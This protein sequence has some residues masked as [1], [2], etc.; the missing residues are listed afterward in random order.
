MNGW[1]DKLPRVTPAKSDHLK[2]VTVVYPYYDQPQWLMKQV[3]ALRHADDTSLVLQ[4]RLS[5]IVVDDGSPRWSA[6]DTLVKHGQAWGDFLRVFRIQQDI[7]WNWLAARNI[8]AH[9]AAGDWLLLTDLDHRI[10]QQTLIECT[11]G[12]HNTNLIYA[13]SRREHTGEAIPPHSASFFLTKE[14]FWKVGGY[15]ETLSGH[16]GT[17]G[18]WRRRCTKTA[19]M[20]VLTNE[21]V[22]YEYVGDSST[23]TYERK[24]PS[25]AAAVKRLVAARGDV[26]RPKVLS[27]PYA[28]VYA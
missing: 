24:K 9:H 11:W 14:M 3:E 22:R 7:P 18:D 27:F 26:W 8:G 6:R 20:Q 10:P 1:A 19:P 21:L 4:G 17:D 13:F 5:V 15:D 23:T 16:Y 28:E 2:T 12:R 25:D